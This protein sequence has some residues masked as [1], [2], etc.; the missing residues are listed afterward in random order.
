MLCILKRCTKC[1]G[2]LVMDEGDWRCMQCARY[3][4][5]GTEG[6]LGKW[7][8]IYPSL[9]TFGPP[10]ETR[11]TPEDHLTGVQRTRNSTYSGNSPRGESTRPYRNRAARSVNSLIQAKHRGETR[12]WDRNRQVIECLD[13][14][15]SVREIS[16]LTNCGERQIRTVRER[17]SDVRAASYQPA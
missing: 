7:Q 3:Y 6:P 15:L 2:D 14:G 9:E 5:S 4:Y 13:R 12:W 11:A 16:L 8:P 10:E 1:R 17:L